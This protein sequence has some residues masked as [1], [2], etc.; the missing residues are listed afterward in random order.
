MSNEEFFINYD[1]NSIIKA[2]FYPVTTLTGND[3]ASGINLAPDTMT[4]MC[5]TPDK[6]IAK[7]AAL[8]EEFDMSLE[9]RELMDPG[10]TNETKLTN[11]KNINIIIKM[12]PDIK[13]SSMYILTLEPLTNENFYDIQKYLS[14]SAT[15]DISSSKIE[16]SFD[17]IESYGTSYKTQQLYCVNSEVIDEPITSIGIQSPKGALIGN[18]KVLDLL[19]NEGDLIADEKTK[20]IPKIAF[21]FQT[22]PTIRLIDF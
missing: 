9:L 12:T 3:L 7:I 15:T 4:V 16:M 14:K 22:E 1:E 11:K 8:E 2:Y 10:S 19:N 5:T 21:P 20:L 18:I 17:P 6:A 13:V